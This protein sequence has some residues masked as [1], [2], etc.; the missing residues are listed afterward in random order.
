MTTFTGSLPYIL[1]FPTPWPAPQRQ[2]LYAY[3]TPSGHGVIELHA[4]SQGKVEVW[5]QKPG[6]HIKLYESCPVKITRGNVAF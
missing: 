5:L 6:E 4:T 3:D 2:I 1:Q